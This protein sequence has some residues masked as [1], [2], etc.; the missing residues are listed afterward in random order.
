MHACRHVSGVNDDVSSGA[1]L[2]QGTAAT[3]GHL[4]HLGS[5]RDEFGLCSDGQG[6]VLLLGG[7]PF[8]ERLLMWWNFVARTRDEV[9]AA[10]VD[11][12]TDARRFGRVA[13]ALP[14]IEVD[15]PAWMLRPT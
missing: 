8:P 6:W 10:Y 2:A 9:E 4:V 5:G 12:A 15:R 1:I 11:W 14:R 7:T 13:S 3:T